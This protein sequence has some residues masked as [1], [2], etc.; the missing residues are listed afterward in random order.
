MFPKTIELLMFSATHRKG[1]RANA[2]AVKVPSI[3]IEVPLFVMFRA[4]GVESDMDI[5]HHV[6]GTDLESEENKARIQYLRAS[7]VDG[8]FVWT[9]ADAFSFLRE[10]CI[11]KDFLKND[12]AKRFDEIKLVLL[13]DVFPTAGADFGAKAMFLG[14][15]VRRFLR[16]AMGAPA[17]DRDNYRHKRVDL[18]GTLLSQLFRDL[19]AVYRNESRKLIEKTYLYGPVKNTGE[20]SKLIHIG[21]LYKIFNHGILSNKIRQSF[22]SGWLVPIDATSFKSDAI[23]SCTI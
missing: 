18:S 19:Y 4:L 7:A 2:I 23:Y 20:F 11:N 17:D 22:R 3:S 14:D 1:K 6:L 5:F 21:N 10:F 8:N 12:D 16:T 13:Q 9:Q 15:A